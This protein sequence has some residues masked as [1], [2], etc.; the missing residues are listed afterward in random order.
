M[1]PPGPPYTSAGRS[2]CSAAAEGKRGGVG[3]L[4]L[5]GRD[6]RKQAGWGV[7]A[8]GQWQA[9]SDG[10]WGI[11]PQGRCRRSKHR[12][13]TQI[14]RRRLFK[15]PHPHT[16][17]THMQSLSPA[18]NPCPTAPLWPPPLPHK[19][20]PHPPR[21]QTAHHCGQR[22]AAPCLPG[23]QAASCTSAW[24]RASSRQHR[25]GTPAGGWR[26][27]GGTVSASV[28]VCVCVVVVVG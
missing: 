12:R 1:A 2:P 4:S 18:E 10:H 16:P 25:A 19:R 28:C 27:V 11:E 24:R 15:C 22:T 6:E 26:G 20:P 7:G 13:M 23:P 5:A 14:G 8:A 21:T 3:M 17:T 9:R